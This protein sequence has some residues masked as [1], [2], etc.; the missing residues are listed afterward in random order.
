MISVGD[1]E[2]LP[3]DPPCV[4]AAC[5]ARFPLSAVCLAEFTGDPCC[6]NCGAISAVYQ[7]GSYNVPPSQ[8]NWIYA[9]LYGL[10]PN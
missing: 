7:I 1:M 10:R 5:A 2:W 3:S 8:V 4:C 6:P 9:S